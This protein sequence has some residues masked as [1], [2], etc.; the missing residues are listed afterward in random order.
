[1]DAIIMTKQF[2]KRFPNLKK[3]IGTVP[4]KSPI[5]VSPK[6]S[7]GAFFKTETSNA[8]V[9]DI[10]MLNNITP[11]KETTIKLSPKSKNGKAPTTLR[12]AVFLT[13]ILSHKIP[14]SAF[15]VPMKT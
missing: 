9:I 2:V 3:K 1:M 7:P 8:S 4:R 10:V 12:R 13:P 5:V 15:P 14:P 11:I 6:A